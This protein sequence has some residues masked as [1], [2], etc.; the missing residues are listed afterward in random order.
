[1]V[2]SVQSASIGSQHTFLPCD[3]SVP[4]ASFRR[5]TPLSAFSQCCRVDPFR[6]GCYTRVGMRGLGSGSRPATR[7]GGRIVQDARLALNL[8]RRFILAIFLLGTLLANGVAVAGLGAGVEVLES[9]ESGITLKVGIDSFTVESL[10]YGSRTFNSIG[11]K[12]F[13]ATEEVGLPQL[14]FTS[15]LVAVPFGTTAKLTI[16]ENETAVRPGLVPM[17][18][19]RAFVRGGEFPTP[20]LEFSM[21][22]SFYAGNVPYP[23]ESARLGKPSTLRHQKVVPIYLFPFRYYPASRELAYSKK[24]VVRL[25]FVKTP[26][27]ETINLEGAPSFELNAEGLYQGLLINYGQAKGWRMKPVSQ[28]LEIGHPVAQ[29]VNEYKMT[30]DSTGLYKVSY[31]DI[32]GLTGTYPIEQVRLFDKFF[33][34][35]SASPFKQVDVP[36]HMVDQNSN[37]YFDGPDY[38]IFYGLSLR[39]RL[40]N[41]SIE[42]RYSNDNVYWLTVGGAQGLSMSE[43]TSWR[44]APAPQEAESFLSVEKYEENHIYFLAPLREDTDYYFWKGVDV[45]DTRLPFFVFAPDTT[46]SWR[47][48]A[49]YQ[50]LSYATHYITAIIENGRGQVDTLFKRA[51]FIQKQEVTLDTDLTIPDSLLASGTSN[52]RY[53][54]EQSGDSYQGS[55]AYF[56]W[57]E[58]SYYR[59]YVALD[60]K[61]AFTSGSLSGEVEI[62]VSGFPSRDIFLCDVTDSLN[63]VLLSIEDWQVTSDNGTYRLLFRDSVSV[64]PRRYAAAE[65]AKIKPVSTVLLDAP[66]SLAV[67]GISK[68]YFIIGYDEFVPFLAPLVSHREAQ[69]HRVEVGTLSDVFD[70]FNG[71]RRS[72]SAIRRYMKYAYTSWGT[73][74]FLLLV[75][76]A[77]EDYKGLT[78]TSAPDYLPTYLILS[79]VAGP[80]G[81]ELVGDDQWYVTGLDGIEDGYPDMYVGRLPVGS[82]L[83]LSP[84]VRK[85]IAYEA[86]SPGQVFRGRGL[87][88]A[89]DAYSSTDMV[90]DCERASEHIFQTIS[91]QAKEIVDE[92]PAAPGFFADTFYLSA[93]LDSV[94]SSPKPQCTPLANLVEYTRSKVRPQLLSKLSAGCLFVNF[95]GHGNQTVMTHEQ[96][97]SSWRYT[98]DVPLVYNYEMPWVYAGFSCHIGDF[99]RFDEKVAGDGMA[100][101]FLLLPTGGAIATFS[102]DAYENLPS[103]THADMNLPFFEAFFGSPPAADL[104][105]K[106]GA[107]WILGEVVTSAKI[108]FLAGDYLNKHTVRTYGLLGDPGLRMEALP[109]QFVVRVDGSLFADGSSVYASSPD[110]S[111]RISVD[112]SDEVGVDENLIRIEESGAEGRGTIPRSEYT[113]TALADTVAGASRRFYLYFPTVLRA[114]TYDIG[115][116]ATDI[117]GRE[118]V[119]TLK[120][121]LKVSFSS[122]GR[123]IHEGDL[124]P[125]TLTADAAVSSP[126][127]LSP[128][129]LSFFV[130]SARVVAR[131]EQIDSSGRAWRVEA[132]IS[133]AD[134]GHVLAVRVGEIERPVNVSVASGFSMRNVFSYPTP[135]AEVTSFNFTLTGTP[136]SALIEVFTVSGRKILE[137]HEQARVGDNSVV[138]DGSD[139]EGHRVANGLYLY[140]ITTTDVG[141]RESSF[142]GKV[143]KV[144]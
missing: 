21:N 142:L 43:R 138:W 30:I 59:K 10:S 124:V 3:P 96:L 120:V 19:P 8:G 11:V 50:G 68:D 24:L 32:P 26:E 58:I 66:S 76:D 16:V 62:P 18:V 38:F 89:D 69:G 137:L 36:I 136:R 14:P 127:V 34:E 101:R 140:R 23:L 108:R 102:S 98:D 110:D 51:S 35:D 65:L 84:L 72:P 61:L 29:V 15:A 87:L 85:I 131:R 106:R 116:Y 27:P 75:G 63:P 37:G 123:T 45:Y 121:D 28:S 113:V 67:S 128:E 100:E 79:P 114:A 44:T 99:D 94:P 71:G 144:E 117:N 119:F 1:M 107:R 133:L 60:G 20:A 47:F 80:Y 134:G 2:S 46:L 132:E 13:L 109:P 122:Q 130:D 5:N 141:G 91:T 33:Q 88:I 103:S 17:P 126:I 111:V 54:G 56:D 52:F 22:E 39:E 83:E 9:N 6:C 12:G 25:D 77:S 90:N 40:P 73:P 31:S 104:R 4:M 125:A 55:G 41:E 135:F 48:R 97:F 81:K 93:Y 129:D 115:L 139:A 74:L 7:N 86:F 105:G 42:W 49:H 57:F 78:T 82:G 112:I 118:T 143:V 70:E 92:S 64:T 95:Q 53:L